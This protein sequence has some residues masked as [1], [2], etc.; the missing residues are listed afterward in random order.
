MS[1]EAAALEMSPMGK[2]YTRFM[3]EL[4]VAGVLL[5]LE[6][7]KG[8]MSNPFMGKFDEGF[9]NDGAK[10]R[11]QQ[12][13]PDIPQEFIDFVTKDHR[14]GETI[15]EFSD[16]IMEHFDVRVHDR[17]F[18]DPNRSQ[19][20]LLDRPLSSQYID[21]WRHVPAWGQCFLREA[22]PTTMETDLVTFLVGDSHSLSGER[23]HARLDEDGGVWVPWTVSGRVEGVTPLNV[24]V[25][26]DTAKLPVD[27]QF[28]IERAM[29][30]WPSP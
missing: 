12:M 20:N 27:V 4:L 15:G 30:S 23:V 26:V 17:V 25:F 8:T 14:N 7:Y 5:T 21:A 28:S 18:I 6:S 16:M 2:E 3:R 9:V 11:M 29:S 22:K 13:L 1:I 19:K 10:K 24:L